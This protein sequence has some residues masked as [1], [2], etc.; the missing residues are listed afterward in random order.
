Q[1]AA[2]QAAATQA[3][4][5]QTTAAPAQQSNLEA[6]LAI[7]IEG[8]KSSDGQ[9]VL[10]PLEGKQIPQRPADPESLPETDLLHWYDMAYAGWGAE[11]KENI[12]ESPKDGCIGKKAIVII[13]GDH[14]YLTAYSNGAKLAG[15]AYKMEIDVKSPNWDLNVQNQMVDQA[16]NARPD[17]IIL[18]AVDSMAAVQQFRKINQAGIPAIGSNML[19]DA[20]AMKYMLTWSGPDDFGQMMMLADAAGEMAGGEGG[21]C[22]MTH[23]PGGSPYYARYSYYQAELAAKYP[24]MKTLDVQSPGFEADKCRQVASDWITRFGDE[25]KVIQLADDNAQATGA[26]EACIAA[27]RTD[28]IITSAGNSKIGMDYL[29]SGD[30][31]ALTYQSAEADGAIAVKLAADWF[32]GKELEDIY[33]LPQHIITASDVDNYMPAQ[34]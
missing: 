13:N 7:N 5:Q 4:E 15:D 31:N 16:I 21:V 24:N 18:V 32:N 2:T 1:A 27:G 8:V 28:I 34:W 19:T 17:I 29:K 22:Y 33:Y 23:N 14:P 11:S 6:S 12:P 30:I 20:E 25:L 10:L 3:A 9:D 26:V